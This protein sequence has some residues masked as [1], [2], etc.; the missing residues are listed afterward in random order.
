MCKDGITATLR[1]PLT[2][3]KCYKVTV[4]HSS[5]EALFSPFV[6]GCALIRHSLVC[7]WSIG[8]LA[9]IY[10]GVLYVQGPMQSIKFVLKLGKITLEGLECNGYVH[11]QIELLKSHLT[12]LSEPSKGRCSVQEH[13]YLLTETQRDV[14]P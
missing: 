3:K 9:I 1:T 7:S 11:T 13:F 5:V 6:A 14:S 10:L 8:Q 2:K 4:Y 12:C